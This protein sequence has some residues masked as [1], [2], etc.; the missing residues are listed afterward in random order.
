[1][2]KTGDFFSTPA[3]KLILLTGMVLQ[4]SATVLVGRYTRSSV[5]VDDLYVVNHLILV[6]EI[7]K[8]VLSC[9]F[10]YVS[11]NGGL[12]QSIKANCIERPWDALKI[13]IPALLYL[14]QNS[15]LYT[16]LSNLT[17][18]VFQVTYQGKL[19]TTAIVS[20][21]MLNRKYSFQQWI[22]LV[23]L[24]VGVAVVVLGESGGSSSSSAES[25]GDQAPQSLVLGLTAVTIAC[26]SSALAGVYFEKVVKT[27]SSGEKQKPVSVWMRNFQL[28]FFTIWTAM[29]Q[30]WWTNMGK[31]EVDTKPYFHG[32]TSWVWILVGLQAG[33]GLLVAAV[34]KYADNVLKGLAT[35]VSVCFATAVS[36]VLFGTP[37]SSQF[38]VGASMI[39][40]SVYFF[41]NPVTKKEKV[42]SS[43]NMPSH[44]DSPSGTP[45]RLLPK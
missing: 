39:L 12:V 18:P 44:P 3:F 25:V 23:V 35:G 29:L 13:M 27:S 24:S 32:F 33:G 22:C 14:V 4:N 38:S 19:V 41:S 20:V 5:P 43:Q 1:M 17:A 10:E 31:S 37:L 15:L 26:L 30:G 11:T 9:M 7:G 21:I 36:T 42:L 8:L 16:A 40:V 34:I 28:A 6:T 45:E 2:S